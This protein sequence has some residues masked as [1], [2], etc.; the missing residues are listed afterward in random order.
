MCYNTFSSNISSL[1]QLTFLKLL[2]RSCGQ[3]RVNRK[4]SKKS[5]IYM[6][7]KSSI[8]KMMFIMWAGSIVQSTWVVNQFRLTLKKPEFFGL[9]LRHWQI[10][11]R[12]ILCA[13]TDSTKSCFRWCVNLFWSQLSSKDTAVGACISPNWTSNSIKITKFGQII[14]EAQTNVN[15]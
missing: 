9:C 11:L 8:C 6:N 2:Q 7:G 5:W 14:S 15:Y 13:F 12:C 1:F 3:F 10:T 4:S